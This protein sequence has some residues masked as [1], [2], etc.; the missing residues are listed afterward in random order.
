[1]CDPVKTLQPMTAAA[2]VLTQRESSGRPQCASGG[3][4]SLT[5][6]WHP[7]CPVHPNAMHMSATLSR[8][9][10][11]TRFYFTMKWHE[12]ALYTQTQCSCQQPCL[13]GCNRPGCSLSMPSRRAW[14]C[15]ANIMH[16]IVYTITQCA[17]AGVNC[18]PGHGI[19]HVLYQTPP[20]RW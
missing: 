18:R 4:S 16:N 20:K 12:Y 14:P 7:A 8:M 15:T 11:W 17:R 6:P 10:Q 1:M 19:E 9:C 3:H 5:T 2:G 13:R